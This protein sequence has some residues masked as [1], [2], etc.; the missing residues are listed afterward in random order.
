MASKYGYTIK[1]LQDINI[2]KLTND[3]MLDALKV[4]T[5]AANK[6]IKR[7]SADKFGTASPAYRKLARQQGLMDEKNKLL[8]VPKFSINRAEIYKRPEGLSNKQ[9]ASMLRGRISTRMATVKDFIDKETSSVT[10][11]KKIRKKVIKRI[12]KTTTDTELDDIEIDEEEYTGEEWVNIWEVISELESRFPNL[13]VRGEK[14]SSV[15]QAVAFRLHEE[16]PKAT[17]DMLIKRAS[18]ILEDV[19]L[20]N[21]RVKDIDAQGYDWSIDLGGNEF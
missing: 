19:E 7:L 3:Q 20:K 6:R 14:G 13:K 16:N 15:I 8:G 12:N 5:D 18:E 11:W 4:M 10:S 21:I 2:N 1:N 17:K 9:W